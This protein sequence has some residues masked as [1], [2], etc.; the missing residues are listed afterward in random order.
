MKRLLK[1]RYSPDDGV[2]VKYERP[3][4][5]QAGFE[6]ITLESA[7]KPLVELRDQLQGMA[8]HLIKIAELPED[9]KL[10]IRSLTITHGE[11]T[12]LVITGLRELVHQNAPLC[13]NSPHCTELAQPC[14]EDLEKLA[15]LVWK[16]VAGEREQLEL[17]FTPAAAQKVTPLHGL[18]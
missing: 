10:E 4:K 5:G 18:S 15:D 8:K 13:I 6:T 7:E 3:V 9:W 16:Y 14:R 12:G 2:L 11:E 17:D 1:F